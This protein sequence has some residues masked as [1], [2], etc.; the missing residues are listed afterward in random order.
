MIAMLDGILEEIILRLRPKEA[1]EKMDT[2]GCLL[3]AEEYIYI[4]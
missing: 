2:L 1:D 3:L 4:D